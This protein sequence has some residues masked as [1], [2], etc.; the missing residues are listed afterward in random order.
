MSTFSTSWWRDNYDTFGGQAWTPGHAD[1]VYLIAFALIMLNTD[2]HRA[3]TKNHKRMTKPQFVKNLAN[4]EY[5]IPAQL[6]EVCN[7]VI[8][9]AGACLFVHIFFANVK[10]VCNKDLYDSVLNEQIQMPFT[11]ESVSGDT[12]QREGRIRLGGLRCEEVCRGRAK[13]V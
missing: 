2:L 13:Y 1:C 7:V 10:S 3:T 9:C 12:A 4:G 5:S 11:E 6:L 8:T